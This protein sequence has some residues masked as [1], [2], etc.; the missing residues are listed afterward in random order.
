MDEGITNQ[1]RRASLTDGRRATILRQAFQ[2]YD[3]DQS[4]AIDHEELRNLLKDLGWPSD[5]VFLQR[6]IN[7]LDADHS[8]VIEFS[9]FLTWT[10]FAYNSRVL[11]RDDMSSS[12]HSM[13]RRRIE[14]CEIQGSEH[15]HVLASTENEEIAELRKKR[16]TLTTLHEGREAR[17]SGDGPI[18]KRVDIL[19]GRYGSQHDSEEDETD[20]DEAKAVEEDILRT[21]K[22][23][24][25]EDRAWNGTEMVLEKEEQESGTNILQRRRTQG[26]VEEKDFAVAIVK[27]AT[28]TFG[29]DRADRKLITSRTRSLRTRSGSVGVVPVS[30]G[31]GRGAVNADRLGLGPRVK[32]KTTAHMQWACEQIQERAQRSE[33]VDAGGHG[34]V[35]VEGAGAD[36]SMENEKAESELRQAR[37]GGGTEKQGRMRE[38]VERVREDK[39]VDELGL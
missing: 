11:Y 13:S 36:A 29:S 10:E 25:S 35:N 18:V 37:G 1:R 34:N 39:Q 27:M 28:M 5:N 14:R 24:G 32:S 17:S 8:G 19:R 12:P 15:G 20:D 4:G 6:A 38:R 22:V 7:V 23:V 9:E 31:D 21:A 26:E 3:R 16:T 2:V 30:D 33:M